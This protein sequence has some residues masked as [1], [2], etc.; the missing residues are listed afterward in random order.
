LSK[1]R[2]ARQPT[3]GALAL[4]F[5]AALPEA[6]LPSAASRPLPRPANHTAPLPVRAAGRRSP[7]RERVES[8]DLETKHAVRKVPQTKNKGCIRDLFILALLAVVAIGVFTW[9]R[10]G[11]KSHPADN[12]AA[13]SPTVNLSED[14]LQLA[15][16][17][18]PADALARAE[19]A[20]K[21][22]RYDES[23]MFSKA[24]LAKLPDQP[25]AEALLGQSNFMLGQ[26]ETVSHLN[27]ALTLGATVTLP[28]RHHHLGGILNLNDGFCSGELLLQKGAIEFRSDNERNHS[29]RIAPQSLIEVRNES[30][31]AGRI[32]TRIAIGRDGQTRLQNY[33]FYPAPTGRR[34]SRLRVSAACDSPICQHQADAIYQ[35]LRQLKP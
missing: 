13:T 31:R 12:I 6:S 2:E 33:N 25:R 23:A 22:G 4:Q 34:A 30:Q 18:P 8:D 14:A 5:A 1:Q 11:G 21:E 26:G 28:I 7:P 19:S 3:A 35:I 10:F 32:H 27:R 15:R 9:W 29:F 16:K 17:M 20:Y 24:V